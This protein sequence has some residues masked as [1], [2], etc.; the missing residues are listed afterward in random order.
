MFDPRKSFELWGKFGASLKQVD[1]VVTCG[2]PEIEPSVEGVMLRQNGIKTY[3]VGVSVL[4]ALEG[5]APDVM[6]NPRYRTDR[7]EV[8]RYLDD[9][10]EKN[11]ERSVAFVRY[12]LP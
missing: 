4:E 8:L 2:V 6:N 5:D 11:G 1:G 7:G 12:V 3:P 9:R 10:L